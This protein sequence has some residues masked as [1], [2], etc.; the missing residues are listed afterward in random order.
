MKSFCVP[1]RRTSDIIMVMRI[2]LSRKTASKKRGFAGDAF[3]PFDLARLRGERA[4]PVPGHNG[5]R[6][7]PTNTLLMVRIT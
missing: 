3:A 4:A 2:K 6:A 1:A 7:H 5:H